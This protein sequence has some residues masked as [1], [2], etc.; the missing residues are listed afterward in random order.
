MY[1]KTKKGPLEEKKKIRKLANAK[2]HDSLT[3][4]LAKI[5]EEK[6]YLHLNLN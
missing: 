5:R 3:I 4:I 6:K 1:N 2:F